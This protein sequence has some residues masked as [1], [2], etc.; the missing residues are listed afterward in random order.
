MSGGMWSPYHGL[1]P[2]QQRALH[3]LARELATHPPADHAAAIDAA[4]KASRAPEAWRTRLASLVGGLS[5]GISPYHGLAT[6][7]QV[8]CAWASSWLRMKRAGLEL[9]RPAAEHAMGVQAALMAAVGLA[10]EDCDRLWLAAEMLAAVPCPHERYEALTAQ[11]EAWRQRLR[12]ALLAGLPSVAGAQDALQAWARQ[13][14]AMERAAR[15]AALAH[16]PADWRPRLTHLIGAMRNSRADVLKHDGARRQPLMHDGMVVS[17]WHV[18]PNGH[19]HR[20]VGP[21][22]QC[23][24]NRWKALELAGI[25]QAVSRNELVAESS[26][27]ERVKLTL[28]MSNMR[29][30][31]RQ[32]TKQ[33]EPQQPVLPVDGIDGAMDYDLDGIEGAV[34]I[35]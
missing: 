34:D 8:L 3:A 14:L 17:G 27:G 35:D 23:T 30:R 20:Y 25:V 1:S 21:L 28:T 7:G 29:P 5:G 4:I 26:T 24:T 16:V 2:E 15:E 13:L 18:R 19:G 10:P 31:K 12:M 22:G 9:R 33:Q 6:A 32:K 11:P